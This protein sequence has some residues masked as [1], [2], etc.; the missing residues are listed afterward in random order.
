MAKPPKLPPVKLGFKN[1][2]PEVRADPRHLRVIHDG[3]VQNE[4]DLFRRAK[5]EDRSAEDL[6]REAAAATPTKLGLPTAWGDRDAPVRLRGKD[7]IVL[8]NGKE[9]AAYAFGGVNVCGECRYFDIKN[10]RTEIIKQKF[11]ERLVREQEWQLKHLGVPADS[12]AL[13]G[14]SGGELAVTVISKSCDQFRPT[15]T[16]RGR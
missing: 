10:G 14:A 4:T 11:G 9:V 1:P 5:A 3:N 13:C 8:A 12:L 16:R 2:A 15:G 6:V 7:A